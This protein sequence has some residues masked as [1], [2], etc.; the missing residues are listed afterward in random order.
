MTIKERIEELAGQADDLLDNIEELPTTEL[1][2]LL[3][4]IEEC[5]STARDVRYDLNSLNDDLDEDKES[6][7]DYIPDDLSAGE[8]DSLKE[9]LNKW[10][11]DNGYPAK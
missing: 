6:L 8:Y 2:S 9:V 4:K 3:E 10:R 5:E 7:L 1:D 11:I